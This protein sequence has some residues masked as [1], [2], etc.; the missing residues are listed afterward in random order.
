MHTQT[1]QKKKYETI[2]KKEVTYSFLYVEILRFRTILQY[3][4]IQE[5][6]MLQYDVIKY[7]FA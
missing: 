3:N 7:L 1:I 6:D 4:M 2:T 5:L